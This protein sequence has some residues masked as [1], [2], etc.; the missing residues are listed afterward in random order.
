[1]GCLSDYQQALADA[2]RHQP[3]S[4]K[5]K[6]LLAPLSA[7]GLAVT[8][9]V[10]TSWTIGRARRGARL[11]LAA[12]PDGERLLRAWAAQEDTTPSYFDAAAEAFLGF[13][14]ERLTGPS[15]AASLCRFERALIRAR[16]AAMPD[17]RPPAFD[18]N[19]LVERT[20]SADLVS[21][22]APIEQLLGAIDGKAP[23][24]SVG[25][26]GW[27]LLIAPGIAGQVR[28][29]SAVE[30]ILWEAA[31]EPVAAGNYWPA[32]RMMVEI[33]ALRIVPR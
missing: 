19:T 3:L 33:G 18:R 14:A 22:H 15:H 13:V 2:V 5:G 16:S 32:A 27:S 17:D 10:R 8:E 26:S 12:L 31:A 7:R 11:T 25:V 4:P 6:A 23:W 30:V 20:P 24:P 21:F 9:R 29:A 28:D 1:M